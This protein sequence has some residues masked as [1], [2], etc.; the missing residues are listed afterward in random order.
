MHNTSTKN[1]R[2]KIK[3][4][5]KPIFEDN[6]DCVFQIIRKTIDS[7]HRTCDILFKEILITARSLSKLYF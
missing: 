7:R 2:K 6:A 5:C 3:D 4:V 1:E